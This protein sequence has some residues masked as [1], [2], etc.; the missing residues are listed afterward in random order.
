MQY[1]IPKFYN[2]PEF[3]QHSSAEEIENE[4]N[5]WVRGLLSK[6][7]PD[8]RQI[9]L[10]LECRHALWAGMVY[11][12]ISADKLRNAC[13]AVQYLFLMDDLIS[14]RNDLRSTENKSAKI[15]NQLKEII[16]GRES[17][18]DFV[19]G[20]PLNDLYRRMRATFTPAQQNRADSALLVILDGFFDEVCL[21]ATGQMIDFDTYY[22]AHQKTCGLNWCFLLCESGIGVDLSDLIHTYPALGRLH[23]GLTDRMNFGNAIFGLPRDMV[24][25][26]IM[27]P[28]IVFVEHHGLSLQNA[29]DKVYNLALEGEKM[30]NDAIQEII[31]GEYRHRTDLLAYLT[32]L[33]YFM[34]GDAKWEEM[35]PRYKGTGYSWG[36]SNTF[37]VSIDTSKE[38]LQILDKLFYQVE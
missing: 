26:D 17:D 24:K 13:D 21:R 12:H 19:F 1:I 15:I 3:I 34:A 9:Q 7:L 18:P 37:S 38:N 8:E 27:N 33:K 23:Q 16:L 14:Y 4:S 11:P 36:E 2:L 20:P 32:N 22:L 31:E 35:T 25:H 28:V 10:F 30:F 6:V 5:E 29:I